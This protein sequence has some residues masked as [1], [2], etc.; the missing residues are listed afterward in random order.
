MQS[1]DFDKK[2]KEAADQHHPPYDERAWSGMKKLLDKHLPEKEDRKRRFI[3]LLLFPLLLAGTGWFLVNRFGGN[4]SNKTVAVNTQQGAVNNTNS[5]NNPA[6]AER[7]PEPGNERTYSDSSDPGTLSE[8]TVTTNRSTATTS[9]VQ[10][11]PG[12]EQYNIAGLDKGPEVI[13]TAAGGQ[14]KQKGKKA[15]TAVAENDVLQK[16]PLPHKKEK[17]P[18]QVTPALP[19]NN[20]VADVDRNK[21]TPGLLA[22]RKEDAPVT[23]QEDIVNSKPVDTK[24]VQGSNQPEEKKKEESTAQQK[25]KSNR[26]SNFFFSVSGG[27]DVSFTGKDK[28]GQMKLVGGAGI[29]YTFKERFTLRTGV[30]SG[31][32]IYTASP[33][34]YHGSQAFYAY[35]P[36]LQKVEADCKVTEW[37]ILLSYNI[38]ASKNKRSNWFVSAGISSL[39]MKRE[40]YDYYYKYNPSGPTLNK[41][42]TF[43]NENKHF[44]SLMTLSAGYQHKLTRSISLTAEPYFKLPLKGVGAGKVKLNSAGVSFTLSVNPFNKPPKK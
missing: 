4:N 19:A 41:S 24:P 34:E 36:N 18:V 26:K 6:S 16:D 28:M 20:N 12:N 8:N 29:G 38:G 30:Y 39:F 10:P 37:P 22:D 21:V 25:R 32:K 14:K 9:S 1:D 40:T 23:K 2:I 13:M 31:R 42:Y 27:P 11:Q 44:F 17:D 35:Y 43:W 3:F 15:V 7:I 5:N 33:D